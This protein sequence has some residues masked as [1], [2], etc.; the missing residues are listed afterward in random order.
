MVF[1]TGIFFAIFASFITGVF[2][3]EEGEE[4]SEGLALSDFR[5]STPSGNYIDPSSFFRFHGYVS[6]SYA[7]PDEELSGGQILVSDVSERTGENEGGF[8]SDAALFVGGEP[9]E[10]VGAVIEIHFV[11]DG[12]DPVI[13]EAKFSYDLIGEE[14]E[15][16]GLRLI[17]GRFWWP[18]GIHDG[19]WFSAVNQFTLVSPAALMVVPP[20]YNEVGLMLEGEKMFSDALGIN[21]VLSYGNGVSG[22]SLRENVRSTSFDQND[23]RTVTGRLGLKALYDNL[24]YEFGF[25][26]SDGEFRD[27]EDTTIEDMT[28]AARFGADFTAW[29]PDLTVG[30]GPFG[31]TAYYYKSE[32]DI[33]TGVTLKRSGYTIE[34]SVRFPTQLERLKSVTLLGRYGEAE[35]ETLSGDD[36]KVSQYGFSVNFQLTRAFFTKIGYMIQDEGKDSPSKDD[37]IF[38]FSFTGEF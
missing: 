36:Q 25:S 5:R 15:D 12:T 17:G 27:G 3:Q 38:S 16:A 20:H 22:F 31:L 29:G 26:A 33:D 37:D 23:N 21:G 1:R 13:T 2:A 18:F 8:K 14:V 10:G 19:E 35:Q 4:A 9:F 34:P 7:S 32:E 24:V 6:L 30:W 11:G 28:D